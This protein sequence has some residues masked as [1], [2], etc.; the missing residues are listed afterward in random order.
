MESW[1]SE[2]G[3]KV[4]THGGQEVKEHF[5]KKKTARESLLKQTQWKRASSPQ[6]WWQGCI[7][8]WK[9]MGTSYS[10]Q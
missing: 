10:N 9:Q 4:K 1:F 2:Y 3:E 6:Q 7:A 5:E 8:T